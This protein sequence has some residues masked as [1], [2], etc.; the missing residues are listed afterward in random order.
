VN[1]AQKRRIASTFEHVDE[2]LH[3]AVSALRGGATGSPFNRFIQDSDPDQQKHV[4]DEVQIIRGQ[5]VAAMDRLG[6]P[7]PTAS[8]PATRS[9]QTDL[10]FAEVDIED[11]EPK[12]LRGY[13]DLLPAEAETLAEINAGLNDAL[14]RM[15]QRLKSG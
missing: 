5:M 7:I 12:R 1:E 14:S 11:L 10:L 9:A 13:G 8:V 6:I 15:N 4:E 3:A 2:L